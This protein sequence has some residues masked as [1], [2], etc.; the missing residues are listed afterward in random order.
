VV[1]P[2]ENE[3]LLRLNVPLFERGELDHLLLEYQVEEDLALL[4]EGAREEVLVGQ[5]LGQHQQMQRKAP[6]GP[7]F[8]GTAAG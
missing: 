7:R 8:G 5:G 3:S 6:H 2:L 4:K 1:G